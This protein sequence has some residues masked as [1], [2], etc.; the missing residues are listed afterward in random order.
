MLVYQRVMAIF[1]WD[2]PWNLGLKNRP[3][4]YGIGTSN[5]SEISDPVPWPLMKSPW[6]SGWNHHIFPM[7]WAQLRCLQPPGG[8]PTG[9]EFVAG[10][11][12]AT[13]GGARGV[14][15]MG[16]LRWFLWWFLWFSSPD[17]HIMSTV[18]PASHWWGCINRIQARKEGNF[19]RTQAGFTKNGG[20]RNS[21]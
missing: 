21:N 8:F 9:A 13:V 14:M 6:I 19:N 2:I 20:I 11:G 16:S 10:R 18:I 5:K 7:V 15:V 17:V 4:I 3:K 12:L 1:C